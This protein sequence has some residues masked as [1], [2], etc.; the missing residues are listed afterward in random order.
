MGIGGY[1]LGRKRPGREAD[2]GQRMRGAI[3]PLPDT[4]SWHGAQLK[5]WRQSAAVMQ[6]EAVIVMEAAVVGVT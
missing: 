2:R 6:R 4:P 5:Y 1:F 3:P